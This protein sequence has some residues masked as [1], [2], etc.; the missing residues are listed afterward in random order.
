MQDNC[1]QL[2]Y[3]AARYDKTGTHPV[4]A[5]LDNYPGRIYNGSVSIQPVPA[6]L[7]P[8]GSKAI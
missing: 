6:G 2:S 1:S 8:G 5:L 7:Q 4:P 3:K